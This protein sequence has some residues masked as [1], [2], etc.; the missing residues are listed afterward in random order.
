M[1]NLNNFH[2]AFPQGIKFVTL[3]SVHFYKI[4]TRV[5]LSFFTMLQNIGTSL[6]TDYRVFFNSFSDSLERARR[7]VER[8]NTRR[9]N[10]R[11]SPPSRLNTPQVDL[12]FCSR[13]QEAV[14]SFHENARKIIWLLYNYL[15]YSNRRQTYRFT[16]F[17]I[18]D[19]TSMIFIRYLLL[20]D[21]D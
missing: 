6:C 15:V 5:I 9:M 21:F 12:T 11:K 18:I 4:I 7:G 10:G 16:I 19:V 14:D 13:K 3:N 2:G 20:I 1:S 17:A 8:E